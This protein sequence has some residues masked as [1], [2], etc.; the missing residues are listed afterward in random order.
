MK[1]QGKSH[2]QAKERGLAQTAS[3]S[4]P[5]SGTSPAGT[6]TLDLWAPELRT[7]IS[8]AKARSVAL[9]YGNPGKLWI[10]SSHL[11]DDQ[12][13]TCGPLEG[14]DAEIRIKHQPWSVWLSG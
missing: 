9:C 2:E 10:H 13:H 7:Q 6:L 14:G 12:S 8:T 1:T 11:W 5:S 3:P 4:W